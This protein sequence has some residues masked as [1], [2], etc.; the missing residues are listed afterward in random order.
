MFSRQGERNERLGVPWTGR[1][2]IP[3]PGSS[4]SQMIDLTNRAWMLTP[5]KSRLVN[6]LL[7]YRS[8]PVRDANNPLPRVDQLLQLGSCAVGL[9]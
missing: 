9:S 8:E 7:R 3:Q 1:L 6:Q 5:V 4:A 2:V